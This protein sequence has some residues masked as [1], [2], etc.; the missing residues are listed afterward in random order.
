MRKDRTIDWVNTTFLTSTP[1]LAVVLSVYYIANYGL[2]WG[3][4]VLF[5]FMYMATGLSIT[6]GY[7]RHYSHCSYDCRKP[8]QIFYLLFGAAAIQNSVLKQVGE[9]LAA[10]KLALMAAEPSSG[11][12][13]DDSDP[14]KVPQ[15]VRLL[16]AM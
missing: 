10:A 12:V 14:P 6:G 3:D 7:H 1:V 4:A 16:D 9:L 5:F 2:H 13:I 8:L 11:A 15:G